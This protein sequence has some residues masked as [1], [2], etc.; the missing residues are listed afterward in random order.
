MPKWWNPS[1]LG[2]GSAWHTWDQTHSTRNFDLSKQIAPEGPGTNV[3]PSGRNI[4]SGEAGKGKL[5]EV[6]RG[7][8]PLAKGIDK[9]NNCGGGNSKQPAAA[10]SPTG[11]PASAVVAASSEADARRAKRKGSASDTFAGLEQFAGGQK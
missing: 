6:T 7:N 8:S 2:T 5:P 11:P 1:N 10:G 3:E 9:D 4:G